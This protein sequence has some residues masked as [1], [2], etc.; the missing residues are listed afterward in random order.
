M[1]ILTDIKIDFAS[2]RAIIDE[3]THDAVIIQ[4]EE[5]ILQDTAIRLKTQ[6]GTVQ[7]Q[8][9]DNFGWNYLDFIKALQSDAVMNSMISEIVRTIRADD[10]IEDCD[11]RVEKDLDNVS[12]FADLKINGNIFPLTVTL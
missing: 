8:N 4:A 6:V 9:L 2:G 11:V 10:R 7:R 1:E 3:T 5:V 12:I